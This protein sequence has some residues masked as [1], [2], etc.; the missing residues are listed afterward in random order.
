MQGV[1]EAL[2]RLPYERRV[3]AMGAVARRVVGPILG[4]PE[5]VRNNLGLVYPDMPSGEVRRLQSAVCDN[6][7]RTLIEF[8][9]MPEFLERAA[10]FPVSG[11][12]LAALEQAREEGRPAI[13][14]TGHFANYDAARAALHQRGFHM[15]GLYRPMRNKRFNDYYLK[16][17]THF[18]SPAV[19]QGRRGT[20]EFL[21]VLKRG[22]MM[23]IL[24][25]VFVIGAPEIP[26]LGVPANTAISAA[27][28]A[29]K[30]GALLVPYFAI[31][32]PDGLS[33]RVEVDA[34]VPH[35]DAVDMTVMLNAALERRV[36]AHPDQW[37]WVHRR[38]K[39]PG[40]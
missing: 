7:G 14:A 37:F 18:G 30:T 15:G 21:R 10:D 34:P 29:K 26:F 13:L 16:N 40:R 32:Q 31:R 5:R 38:W 8:F 24:F 11:P 27:E 4:W 36:E 2:L 22:G 9:S 17:I 33:F 28:M 20:A 25:D 3:P 23:V 35:G 6:V 12:G 19:A 1:I 39:G